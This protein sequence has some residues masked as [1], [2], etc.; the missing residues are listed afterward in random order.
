MTAAVPPIEP[1]SNLYLKPT[2]TE[3]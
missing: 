1:C 3:N 2:S